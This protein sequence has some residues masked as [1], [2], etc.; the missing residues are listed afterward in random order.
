MWRIG[1][2]DLENYIISAY[3]QTAARILN[4]DLAPEED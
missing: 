2:T 3:E 4:G 1:Q